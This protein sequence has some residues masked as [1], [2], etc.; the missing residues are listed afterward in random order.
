[1]ATALLDSERAKLITFRKLF[2]FNY[3]RQQSDN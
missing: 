2:N 1:M 3:F